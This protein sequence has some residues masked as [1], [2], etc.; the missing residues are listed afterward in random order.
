MTRI[1]L[2]AHGCRLAELWYEAASWRTR[3]LEHEKR[4]QVLDLAT[5]I[6]DGNPAVACYLGARIYD[7]L[8]YM[9]A[10]G[11]AQIWLDA[12]ETKAVRATGG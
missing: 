12:I 5:T 7:R 9:G 6:A 4:D 10:A 2:D 8:K 3:R 1:D 11:D